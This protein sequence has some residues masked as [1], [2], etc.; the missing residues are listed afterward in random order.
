MTV[1]DLLLMAQAVASGA[2]CGLIWFVQV[3]H[4]PLFAR[5]TGAGD[6]EYAAEHQRRTAWVVIPF[7]L[8]EG[9][10]AALLAITPPSG[11]PRAAAGAGL[12]LVMLVWASTAAVQM[13][14]H[15]RLGREGHVP[16]AVAALVR[17]NWPRTVLWTARAL[18]AVWMLR[19]GSVPCGDGCL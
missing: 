7:M 6:R 10:V 5:V 19:A 15:G 4:Y 14:L 17:S 2:M 1:T 13:P 11:I 18:L 9:A 3:V 16:A 8:V 12:G